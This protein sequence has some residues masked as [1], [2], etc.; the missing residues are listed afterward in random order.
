MAA[1]ENLAVAREL[2]E[3]FARGDMAR[4]DSLVAD[5][6]IWHE[7]GRSEPRIGKEALRAEAP[8]GGADFEIAG[9]VHDVLASDD[10]A[11]A[12]IEATATRG[13]KVFTYRTAEVYH[14]LGGKVVERWAFSDDTGAIAAFF[15]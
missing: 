6:V 11:I 1:H 3:A 5:D 15:A 4:L 8:G 9:T 13:G 7:I 10:H 14:I 2:N 12:L